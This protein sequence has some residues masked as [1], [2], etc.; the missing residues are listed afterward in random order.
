[1]TDRISR[2]ATMRTWHVG[3]N[4]K[5][6]RT[7]KAIMKKWPW[8]HLRESMATLEKAGLLYDA[9][10]TF[11]DSLGHDWYAAWSHWIKHA[12]HA[13]TPDEHKRL[14]RIY[15]MFAHLPHEFFERVSIPGLMHLARKGTPPNA[16][17]QVIDQALAGRKWRAD[18]VACLLAA[19]AVT[20]N[21]VDTVPKN[22]TRM[23]SH[24]RRMRILHP[25]YGSIPPPPHRLVE[26]DHHAK[27]DD[28]GESI[29]RHR[30]VFRTRGIFKCLAS[31]VMSNARELE[32]LVS[33][34][35]GRHLSPEIANA[36][37]VI[38]KHIAESQPAFVDGDGWKP[39]SEERKESRPVW[40]F[41]IEIQDLDYLRQTESLGNNTFWKASRETNNAPGTA[42][43]QTLQETV[44]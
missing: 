36:M 44:S 10:N 13:G 6:Q 24:V 41:L 38:S 42:A 25:S 16:I 43:G 7:I 14:G 12:L 9:M 21:P 32:R 35:A 4:E 20:T 26:D 31:N 17:Q 5:Q 23:L 2:I 8:M 19:Y 11:K 39:A 18:E 37:K 27:F 3:L 29:G 1:M 22:T 33:T 30:D 28:K 15:F 34:E 40:N